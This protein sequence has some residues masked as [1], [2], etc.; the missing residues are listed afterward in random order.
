MR[1]P[2]EIFENVFAFVVACLWLP[3]VA[4]AAI[5]IL[6]LIGAQ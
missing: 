6:M 5:L 3:A 1:D 4:A 2:I